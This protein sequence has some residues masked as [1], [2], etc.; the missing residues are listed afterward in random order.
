M[1][2]PTVEEIRSWLSDGIALKATHMLIVC[3]RYDYED[4]P[5]YVRKGEDV[6]AI[7]AQHDG[8]NMTKVHCTFDY[9]L[10]L[11]YQLREQI[12]RLFGSL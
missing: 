12:P 1:H 3:D 8:P 10:S 9:N 6:N 2:S 4:F 5:V 11:E 7:V